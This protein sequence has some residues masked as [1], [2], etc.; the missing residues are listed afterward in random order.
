MTRGTEKW[1]TRYKNPVLKATN[2]AGVE[3]ARLHAL[4]ASMSFKTK[5]HHIL[6]YQK[7]SV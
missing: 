5:T 1:D 7:H 3:I 4:Q 2:P 6:L